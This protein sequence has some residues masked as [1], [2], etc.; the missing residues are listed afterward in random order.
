MQDINI[1]K[2]F[3]SR[4]PN[5]NNSALARIIMK[6]HPNMFN[7][8]EWG[9]KK[10]A[11]IRNGD[12]GLKEELKTCV[13]T[14][15]EI[16]LIERFRESKAALQQECIDKG[17]D[18]RDVKQFWLK[19]KKWSINAAPK[20]K[21]I[22]E[23][24]AELIEKMDKYS[25]KY[26][27]I[28]RTKHKDSCCLVI[29]LA[30]IHIG[31]LASDYETGETYNTKIAVKRVHEGV[32]G[33]L[34]KASGFNFDKVILIIGNDILHTDD[35]KGSTTKG[36]KQD[37]DGMWYDNFLIAQQLYVN[38]I[39]KLMQIADVHVIHN[40]SNH[41]TMTG[42]FLAQNVS[43]WFNRSKN[44]SFDVTMKHRK[45]V[46]YHSSLIGSTHGDGA[47]SQDLPL[48]F[49]REFKEHWGIVKHCY[50]YRHHTHHKESKDFAG[51]TVETSRSPSSTDAWHSKMGYQGSKT[52]IEGYV[53]DNHLGQIS[54]I[55]HHSV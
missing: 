24:K 8:A 43:I 32:D 11:M 53:N 29:D 28:K 41:D 55:T 26:V 27:P 19:S 48:L 12:V 39:E 9:R 22:E 44:V 31:K 45:A 37:T 21:G 15:D 13:L 17:I 49:A 10:I 16:D 42:W 6:Q 46:R 18:F 2:E 54:R 5:E 25:P 36:T 3:I 47:K 51:V 52:A 14:Q 40:V 1:I 20:G 35:T 7:S 23:L 4:Y 34:Q 38:I 33:I 30:D 50:I